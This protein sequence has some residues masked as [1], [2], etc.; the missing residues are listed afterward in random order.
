MIDMAKFIGKGIYKRYSQE[1][2]LEH[3]IIVQDLPGLLKLPK[4]LSENLIVVRQNRKLND[5]ELIRDEDE[6][7]FFLAIMGG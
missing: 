3:P 7:Y 4:D 2:K 1:R 5:D 6:I